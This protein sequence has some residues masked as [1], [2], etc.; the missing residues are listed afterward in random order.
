MTGTDIG[1]SVH[2]FLDA[3]VLPAWLHSKD[4][5]MISYRSLVRDLC[6]PD[7]WMPEPDMA[8]FILA[9]AGY[10]VW[11]GN[12]RGSTYSREHVSLKST[13]NAFWE[14]RYFDCKY[15]ALRDV[16]NI[17]ILH[18]RK[19]KT[20]KRGI[21]HI[22]LLYTPPYASSRSLQLGAISCTHLRTPSVVN[23]TLLH[24]FWHESGVYDLPAMIDYVLSRT[25]Q[26]NLYYIG[27][28]MGTTMFYVMASMR[29]EYNAK[30]RAQF[31]LAPVAFMS[32][33]KSPVAALLRSITFDKLEAQK[34]ITRR[35]K[36]SSDQKIS[37]SFDICAA[38]FLIRAPIN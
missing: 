23:P 24:Q 34:T 2:K 13:D 7:K 17:L 37:N 20:L 30:I 36:Q 26:S 29:P 38:S 25:S 5:A 31:S 15:L 35:R 32:N 33:L 10:D 14:F 6:S 27:H 9:D 12:T 18:G 8:A 16:Q 28:S 11:L 3:H 19:K 1:P 21:L 22:T 4:I